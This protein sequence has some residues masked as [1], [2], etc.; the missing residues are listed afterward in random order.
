MYFELGQ[1]SRA[2][3]FEE[4]VLFFVIAFGLKLFE[5]RTVA[6]SLRQR[7][8][9]LIFAHS[10]YCANFPHSLS[11]FG[12]SRIRSCRSTLRSVRSMIGQHALDTSLWSVSYQA[13]D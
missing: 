5:S 7:F 11:A 6:Q 4:R 10:S 9:N 8:V 12:S 1:A 13:N 3:L 2:V